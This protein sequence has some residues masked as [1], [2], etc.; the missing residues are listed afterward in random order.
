M[1]LGDFQHSYQDKYSFVEFIVNS[2]IASYMNVFKY[3]IGIDE[4]IFAKALEWHNDDFSNV[5]LV[6]DAKS[7]S[8]FEKEVENS[9]AYV[10]NMLMKQLHDAIGKH[11]NPRF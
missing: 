6:F 2:A 3:A 7:Y 8:S 1:L 10:E 5:H 11:I 4:G 9:I